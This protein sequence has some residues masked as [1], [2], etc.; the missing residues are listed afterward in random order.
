MP[1]KDSNQPAHLCSLISHLCLQLETALRAIHNAPS[2]DSDQTGNKQSDLNLCWARMFK[3][4]FSDVADLI[5][6]D[7]PHGLMRH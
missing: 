1:N 4:K 2:D 6:A 3:D 7:D 5:E